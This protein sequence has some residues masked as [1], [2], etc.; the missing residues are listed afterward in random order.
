MG[1]IDWLHIG[2]S[3]RVTQAELDWAESIILAHPGMPTIIS[4]HVM[5]SHL[6]QLRGGSP[7]IW[8]C[9]NIGWCADG[10]GEKI[11]DQLSRYPQVFLNLGGHAIGV[12]HTQVNHPEG[13]H[14]VIGAMI[15]Y[16]LSVEGGASWAT[17]SNGGG[18]VAVMMT[19]DLDA[20]RVDVRSY[21]A[22][23][24]EWIPESQGGEWSYPVAF[25]SARFDTGD[26]CLASVPVLPLGAA[27]ALAVALA[28]AAHL[29]LAIRDRS[30]S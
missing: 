25:C 10:D 8:G 15:D 4:T 13:G 7:F 24:D 21:S 19:F 30:P 1:G 16:S 3:H 18:G 6:A 29:Y 28:L 26:G 22:R 11:F 17:T 12:S 14:S 5:M 9:S 2:V 23:Q 27:L 20:G